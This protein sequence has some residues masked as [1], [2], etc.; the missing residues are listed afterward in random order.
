MKFLRVS[1]IAPTTRAT[2]ERYLPGNYEVTFSDNEFAYVK[3]EDMAGWTAE[4]YVIP[5]L[6]SG[7]IY[8]EKINEADY[9]AATRPGE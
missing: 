4:D 7:M 9:V 1:L 6:Q 5:R 3:G 2:V 8:A